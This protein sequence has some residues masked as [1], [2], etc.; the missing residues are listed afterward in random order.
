MNYKLFVHGDD[1]E[2]WIRG[3]GYFPSDKVSLHLGTINFFPINKNYIFPK[4]TVQDPKTRALRIR[5]IDTWYF[6]VR[7]PCAAFL[8][9]GSPVGDMETNM[10]QCFI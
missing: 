3:T 7:N 8:L 4:K 9:S 6:S 2:I 10:Q 1:E 5:F